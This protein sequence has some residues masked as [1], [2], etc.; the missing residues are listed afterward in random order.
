ML[1]IAT[2]LF[3]FTFPLWLSE[4]LYPLQVWSEGYTCAE[5]CHC[6]DILVHTVSDFLTLF[7][8]RAM[9]ECQQRYFNNMLNIK[10]L[11]VVSPF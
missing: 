8:G 10:C 4:S 2:L 11:D 7:S 5:L 6:L 9:I 3:A 1:C